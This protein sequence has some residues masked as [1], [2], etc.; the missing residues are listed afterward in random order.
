MI[1]NS[2]RPNLNVSGSNLQTKVFLGLGVEV[3]FGV[4]DGET[5]G[6]GEA[7]ALALG[8]TEGDA[9]A[10]ALG[11][12]VGDSDGLALG[13]G[14]SL[15]EELADGEA[16]GLA[17]GDSEG[18]ALGL[19]D[20]SSD[21]LAE[22]DALADSLGL[23]PAVGVSAEAD[24]FW[25]CEANLKTKSL[26]LL[27]V[28]SP[29]PPAASPANILSAVDAEL[30]FLSTLLF[31]SGAVKEVPSVN[32]LDTVPKATAS[33]RLPESAAPSLN[34]TLLLFETVALVLRSQPRAALTLLLHQRKNPCAGI[35]SSALN[36][37]TEV[38]AE[39]VA[40]LLTSLKS[41]SATSEAVGL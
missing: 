5:V 24:A 33:I 23:G 40:V 4:L 12:A 30:A 11:L 13:E 3:G 39:A 36:A 21:G 9:E 25:G 15:G 41:P 16:E 7:E 28:S 29:F 8:E 6:D 17:E 20:G 34:A 2:H 27:S 37:T 1:V 32:P 18:L 22:G 26:A 19:A 31:A 10:L 38:S 14:D 35:T